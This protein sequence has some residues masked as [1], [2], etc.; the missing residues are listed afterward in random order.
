MSM[1]SAI[2]VG[3]V[4][5]R[6][7]RV[8]II[9]PGGGL[10]SIVSSAIL[11]FFYFLF[12]L[13]DVCE[14][15]GVGLFN[16]SKRDDVLASNVAHRGELGVDHVHERLHRVHGHGLQQHDRV[17]ELCARDER[18]DKMKNEEEKEKEKKTS[19]I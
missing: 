17:H 13:A 18:N 8:W 6:E 14:G 5:P 15:V 7:R 1:R 19:A 10:R 2:A 9:F 11:I 3:V 4:Y 12:L 16:L